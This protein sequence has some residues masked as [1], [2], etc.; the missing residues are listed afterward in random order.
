MVDR[1]SMQRKTGLIFLFFHLM[2]LNLFLHIIQYV[3]PVR[4]IPC[5]RFFHK[6]SANAIATTTN[7][8]REKK[9]IDLPLH[10]KTESKRSKTTTTQKTTANS[11][12]IAAMIAI[13]KNATTQQKRRTEFKS[14]DIEYGMSEHSLHL[15]HIIRTQCRSTRTCVITHENR[16]K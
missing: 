14:F 13:G 10:F 2:S 1:Q 16:V 15:T 8:S 4:M 5:G 7:K 11:W 12:K 9:P 3:D 6:S